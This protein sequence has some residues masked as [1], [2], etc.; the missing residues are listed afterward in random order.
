MRRLRHLVLA[1]ALVLVALGQG[2]MPAAAG[3]SKWWYTDFRPN[4]G[5]YPE[6]GTVRT[7]PGFGGAVTSVD[8][9]YNPSSSCTASTSHTPHYI[10]PQLTAC[11]YV[12]NSSWVTLTSGCT[13]GSS[14]QSYAI[15]W[16]AVPGGATYCGYW[17]LYSPPSGPYLSDNLNYG[18]PL[19]TV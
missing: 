7:Y 1:I 12:Y 9:Y 3:F 13:V 10:G 11:T 16:A 15:S 19:C 8:A 17:A 4:G 5:Y 2:A 6:C 18:I 14:G